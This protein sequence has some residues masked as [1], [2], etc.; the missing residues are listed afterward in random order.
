[1]PYPE[2][3]IRGISTQDAIGQ[4]KDNPVAL[5]ALFQFQSCRSKEKPWLEDSINWMDDGN[6]I[7]FTLKQ[8]KNGELQFKVGI[9]TLALEKL[10]LVGRKYGHLS[11]ERNA[12]E[13]KMDP[14]KNNKYH[15][16]LL[17]S[18]DL[19]KPFKNQIRSVLA[20]YAEVKLREEFNECSK[21][22]RFPRLFRGWGRRLWAWLT[23]NRTQDK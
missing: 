10:K 9:A 1:M 18:R 14:S 19:Q 2:K 13:D 11:Y 12:I 23:R 21:V 15:G 7:S 22:T 16:N 3:C 5:A 4:G 17:L 6:A 20:E 8:T